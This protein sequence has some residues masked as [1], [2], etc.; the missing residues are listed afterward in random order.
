MSLEA[1]FKPKSVAVIGASGTPGK[2]GYAIM[3]NL[4]D[5]GYEGKIYAVNVKGGEIEI[6]GR[7]F[8]V[9]KSILDVPDEV[10]MA[11][12]VV[13][14]KFVPQV[15]EE[16]G[17]KGV[18][19][20]PI[21][22]SGF[23]ELGEEGKKV[24]QQLVE[25]AHKYGMRILGPNI[26]GVVY[27]PAKLNATFGPTDVMPGKLALISQSGALG[28][29]LM[30]WTI[31]EKVGLSAVVSVG[32]KSDIDDADLLEYFETDENTGA[33]LI[34]MEGV[35][36]GRKFMEVAKKVSM[37]KPIIII[38]AGRSERG[39]KAAASHTGSLA[40]ADNIYTAAFK[41]SGVLRALT[42]GE[43]FD[44]ARTLSNLPE[45]QGENVVI[46]TNGGGIGVMATDAAEE[47]GLKLYD[48]LEELKVFANHM[49]PFGSYKN[50]VDLTGMAGAESYEGAIRDAL[51][52]PE[53][54]AIAVLYCQT[55][56]LDP[57]DLAKIVIKEYEASGRKKPLVV[58]IVGG[59]EAKEAIDML[60]EHGIPAYPEPER[61]I[62]SLAALYKW[63]HWKMKH[64]KE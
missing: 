55:A 19:V 10:D 28:I 43:A 60:N 6:G 16:C 53:M 17:K 59:V 32:N 18:K 63:H 57:R 50:P 44:W 2:I 4:I 15:V 22:S 46:L 20:L 36:D 38:K 51:A 39:A 34:Y 8:P 14:A 62:K 33:I 12:I 42:I 26:F 9:Y 31:L 25:T 1:L 41:Q 13:P 47:E 58:A 54:H 29:A 45:P 35:K 23:G 21:I 27:T 49:P 61:A 3:K 56:V 7:K 40:G 64:K 48:N 52:H 24:E 11:V 30:G 37:K 5:Y